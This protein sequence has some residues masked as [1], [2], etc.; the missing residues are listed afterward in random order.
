MFQTELVKSRQFRGDTK[1]DLSW[2]IV[3]G[4]LLTFCLDK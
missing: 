2:E 4:I 3:L 1:T